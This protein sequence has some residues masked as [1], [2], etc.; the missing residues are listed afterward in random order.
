MIFCSIGTSAV[1]QVFLNLLIVGKKFT[2]SFWR[3]C[4]VFQSVIVMRIAYSISSWC[5]FANEEQQGQ[6]DAFLKQSYHFGFVQRLCTFVQ[7]A[8]CTLF[9][10]T[11]NPNYCI[12]LHVMYRPCNSAFH[13][14]GV[15]KWVVSFISWCYTVH[16]VVV[17]PGE[18]L[19]QLLPHAWPE[20]RYLQGRGHP[21]T[22]PTCTFDLYK[23]SFINRCLFSF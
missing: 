7:R 23:N 11:A 16:S 9:A 10:S 4:A 6:I 21:Y 17:P 20:L 22:L 12:G 19:H 2:G 15:Y 14:H 5:S 3:N 8:D 13:P 18:L 1:N